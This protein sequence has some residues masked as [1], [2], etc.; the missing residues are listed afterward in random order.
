MATPASGNSGANTSQ[1]PATRNT[2][3]AP[4][5][6]NVPLD[7]LPANIEVSPVGLTAADGVLS[8]GLYYRPRGSSPKVGVHL[9]HPRT[10]QSQNYNILPLVRSGYGVLGRGGRWPNNDVNTVH[11]TLLLDMA[12]GIQFLMDQ[13]CE[14]V[15]LLGNSGGSSLATFYQW[16]ARTAPPGRLISTPAG[17]PYDLNS[18]SLPAAS[19]IVLVAGHIGEGALLEKMI[20]PSVV[21]ERDPLASDDDLDP[22]LPKNG[23]RSPP[24][25]STYGES[26]LA[27]YRAAQ[28]A[29]M[30][31]IDAYARSLI[32]RQREAESLLPHADPD[33]AIRLQRQARM[34]WHIVVYR[35]TADPAAVDL[36]IDP[37]DRHVQSYS[38]KRPDLE[39][40]GE[41]GFARY[42]TPRAWLSTWSADSSNAR[43][44]DNLEMIQDPLLIVHY[45][46]DAGARLSEVREMERRSGASDKTLTI[47]RRA[48][49]YGFCIND[50]GSIGERCTEGTAAV[51]DW[52]S[53][54]FTP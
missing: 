5:R 30:R 34:G 14:K 31:R 43:T 51:V 15:V 21:D 9:M 52:M 36:S 16:Q 17:D 1:M 7:D 6:A 10:D 11:E 37:D 45:A 44:I 4:T 24:A 18:F 28:S 23:F 32:E 40:Y 22:Y 38:G 13:G 42:V 8:K 29:R 41:N 25:S 19:A 27:A 54:R 50:D 20:D 26:F 3:Q 53:K 49:H 48:D 12:A 2:V 35:T 39:N 46:G 33:T 47:I